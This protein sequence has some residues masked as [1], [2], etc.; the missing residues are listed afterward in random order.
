MRNEALFG[1]KKTKLRKRHAKRLIRAGEGSTPF[2]RGVCGSENPK[3]K[4]L[5]RV[6]AFEN[7]EKRISIFVLVRKERPRR[8]EE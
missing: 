2:R 8:K 5:F 1:K 4:A 7:E 6:S 3:E